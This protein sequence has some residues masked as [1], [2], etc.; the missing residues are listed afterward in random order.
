MEI[1]KGNSNIPKWIL[2]LINLLL[3]TWMLG[4]REKINEAIKWSRFKETPDS[5]RAPGIESEGQIQRLL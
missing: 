1:L 5:G 2:L 3:L 4:G